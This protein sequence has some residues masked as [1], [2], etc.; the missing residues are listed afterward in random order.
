MKTIEDYVDTSEWVH[1]DDI[2]DYVMDNMYDEVKEAV[3]ENEHD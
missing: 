2:F 3:A 1:M